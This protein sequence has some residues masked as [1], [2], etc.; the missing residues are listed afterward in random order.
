MNFR[1]FACKR[2]I[3][4]YTMLLTI[5]TRH[6]PATDLGFLLYK[7]PNSMQ[8]FELPFGIAHVFYPEATEE[9]CTVALLLD[10]DPIALVRGRKDGSSEGSLDNY[11]NDRPYVASSFLSVAIAK[12]FG[13]AL[14]GKSKERPELVN[15]AIPLVASISAIDCG[16]D[17][18]LRR[19]FEPLG[20]TVEATGYDLDEQFGEWGQSRYYSVRLTANC[21]LHDLLSHLYVLIPV[22]DNEKHYW[23]SEDEVDKLLRHGEGW[24]EKHPERNFITHR[25]LRHKKHLARLALQRLMED[26]A[27]PDSTEEKHADEEASIE[28]TISL[29]ER[30]MGT[31]LAVLKESGSKRIIDMGC[32]SGKLLA[33]LFQEK[34]FSEIVGIDVSYYALEIAKKRLNL[35]DLPERQKAR[36]NLIQGSLTYRDKRFSGF[37]AAAC[38][39]V[40]EHLDPPR[41]SAFERVI[42]EFASPKTVVLTTPNS[43]YNCL[44]ETLPV[45]T[46]RHRDHR[47]EWTRQE[48]RQWA[49]SVCSRFGYNVR[50]LPVGDEH[51]EFGAPTQMGVFTK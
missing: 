27:D 40:I 6:Q 50:Y 17:N 26:E 51:P 48:F 3:K 1:T 16:S 47:F 11:V 30:R 41:L 28:K 13:S 22:L 39:E 24:L 20:Y 32:G 19:L 23:V 12:I 35:D 9:Q 5:S 7:N 25:Y 15:T 4:P 36:L 38:I 46:F 21:T 43:E 34:E 49:E 33:R 29:N 31:V 14:S 45:G 18:V 42:F 44:F 8:S 37:D 2:T 10:I